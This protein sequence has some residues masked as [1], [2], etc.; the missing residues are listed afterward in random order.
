[1]ALN[2]IN[3][4]TFTPIRPNVLSILSLGVLLWKSINDA[5]KIFIFPSETARDKTFFLSLKHPCFD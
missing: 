4:S 2:L 1:M 5:K 3:L